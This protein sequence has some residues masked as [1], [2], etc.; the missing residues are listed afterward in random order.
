MQ[1]AIITSVA[2]ALF[3]SSANAAVLIDLS[4]RAGGVV[5]TPGTDSK[6]WNSLGGAV[7]ATQG[8]AASVP[9]TALIDENNAPL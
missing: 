4:A 8:P 7:G 9:A 1:K 5:P 6:Y 3:A 2:L